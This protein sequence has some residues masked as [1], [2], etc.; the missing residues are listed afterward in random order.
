MGRNVARLD[1]PAKVDGSA[2]FAI[3]ARVP[4]MKHAAIRAA[5]VFGARVATLD[6][7]DAERQPG[8]HSV[9]NLDDA[10]AVIADGYWQASRALEQ[11]RVSWTQT[12]HEQLD[13]AAI[14]ARFDADLE[15]ARSSGSTRDDVRRGDPEAAFAGADRVIEA[16]YRVPWLAHTT[17]EPM[18]ATARMDGDRCE[19]WTGT[20]N[21]LG[22]RHEVAV[23]LDLDPEQ[24]RVHQHMMGGGF[25]RRSKSDAAIQAARL[26]RSAGVPVKLIWSREEDVRH[27]FYRPAVTSHFRAALSEAG[28]ILAWEHLYHEKHEPAEAPVLPY[29]IPAQHIHHTESPTH[30]PFGPWRSVDHSQHGYFTEAFLDEL[31]FA[32]GRDPWQLRRALLADRPRHRAVLD[33][34]AEKADWGRL[35]GPGRGRGIS[36]QES[37]GTIVAQVVDVRVDAGWVKVERV[38]CAVD[39]GFAVSPDGV[40]AQMESG[41]LYG[42]TAALYGNIEIRDGAVVQGNFHD[43]KAVRMDEAPRIETHIIDSHEPWGGAGEPG[44]PGIAPALTAAVFQATGVRVRDLPLSKHRLDAPIEE[45]GEATR[46]G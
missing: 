22:C 41:I 19:V 27:D 40:R 11:V 8:V 35:P 16:R 32:A 33:L 31:A 15:R 24:V 9:V 44:T 10:V 6:G 21:P 1:I 38:V 45:Q 46:H 17:M 34:A 18:N 3:D 42:L 7:S 26:A 13:S 43:Y 4:G 28:E 14:R 29:A 37:F 36:L 39:C 2:L 23:A 5:P 30:V 25:G 12:G 20:Q